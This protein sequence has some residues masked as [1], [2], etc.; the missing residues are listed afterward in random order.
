MQI[1]LEVVE[2]QAPADEFGYINEDVI[3]IALD[4]SLHAVGAQNLMGGVC[5]C[6]GD[7]FPKHDRYILLPK[8][9]KDCEA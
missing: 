6:C 1:K 7:N 5:N 4:G 2:G 3:I 9:I 8:N